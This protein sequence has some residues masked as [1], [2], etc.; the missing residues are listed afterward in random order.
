MLSACTSH[1]SLQDIEPRADR[2]RE[3]V[4]WGAHTD[5]NCIGSLDDSLE[6]AE[7]KFQGF[8]ARDGGT[9]IVDPGLNA[10]CI[11]RQYSAEALAAVKDRD[12]VAAYAYSYHLYQTKKCASH[13]EVEVELE[14]AGNSKVEVERNSE[15]D[16]ERKSIGVSSA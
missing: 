7:A 14:F 16:V 6:P 5:A 2:D 11:T 15:S 12:P 8:M 4:D 13:S 10:T 9:L 1:V 3:L